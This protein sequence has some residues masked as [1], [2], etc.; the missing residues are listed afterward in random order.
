MLNFTPHEEKKTQCYFVDKNNTRIP[1]KMS[2]WPRILGQ[3]SHTRKLY[4]TKNVPN[5]IF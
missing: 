2:I 5:N 1:L 3:E 4:E